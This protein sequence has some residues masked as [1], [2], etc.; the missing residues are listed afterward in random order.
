MSHVRAQDAPSR[1][2]VSRGLAWSVPVIGVAAAAPAL[3]TSGCPD[4]TVAEAQAT[5]TSDSITLTNSPTSVPIPAGTTITWQLQNRTNVA[6]TV[7]LN[8][9]VGL[10]TSPLITSFAL[11]ANGT[12]TVT[13]TTTA[14]WPIGGTV[15]FNFDIGSAAFAAWNL[16]SRFTLS[17]YPAPLTGCPNASACRSVQPSGGT[18]IYTSTCPTAPAPA[19][20]ARTQAVPAGPGVDAPATNDPG[21]YRQ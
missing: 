16:S 11:P 2:T 13:F 10:Q 21:P 15:S 6:R 14:T 3:A 1:R 20:A 19:V 5:T 8:S 4:I 12:V 18:S 7:T 9:L 17:A